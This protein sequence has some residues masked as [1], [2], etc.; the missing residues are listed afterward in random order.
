[1]QTCF[2]CG[3]TIE[4]GIPGYLN[5]QEQQACQQTVSKGKPLQT[6]VKAGM[7]LQ[8]RLVYPLLMFCLPAACQQSTAEHRNE[9]WPPISVRYVY[10]WL[11]SCRASNRQA[12]ILVVLAGV[13]ARANTVTTNN[14]VYA[15]VTR[16]VSA[17]TVV[18]W[19]HLRTQTVST[20]NTGAGS[21][22]V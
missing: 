9:C 8:S 20:G 19:L 12:A 16:P 11:L 22:K 17:Y 7:Q 15:K 4:D 3:P 6:R 14:R 10:A 1:M 18:C 21:T 2:C 13:L 5:F